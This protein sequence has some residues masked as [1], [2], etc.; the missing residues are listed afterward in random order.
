MK[1]LI[2]GDL[3]FGHKNLKYVNRYFRDELF[4]YIEDNC[5][6]EV[7]CLGDILDKRKTIDFT[8][9]RMLKNFLNFFE[10]NR[11]RFRCIVGNHD[12]YYKNTSNV[13]GIT[14]I[15]E[16]SEYIEFIDRP[17]RIEYDGCSFDF[18]PWINDGNKEEVLEYIK[19][20]TSEY[21]VGHLELSGFDLGGGLKSQSGQ[22][23]IEYL[24]RYKRVFSGHFHIPSETK[25][26][27]YVG[28][29]YE[30]TFADAVRPKRIIVFNTETKEYE[31]I[32]T[33]LKLYEIYSVYNINDLKELEDKDF[34]N[35]YIKILVKSVDINKDEIRYYLDRISKKN[36][37]IISL[38]IKPCEE[39]AGVSS[40]EEDSNISVFDIISK[41]VMVDKN[42]VNQRQVL[43]IL[44][45]IYNIAEVDN[46][47]V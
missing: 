39:V 15:F 27:I 7:I 26:I 41:Y 42:V 14:Q 8:V 30:L 19:S 13:I 16:D 11:V 28:T 21:L 1:V 25:N 10:S 22:M 23:N 38:Y 20:S 17:R 37:D 4:S 3:H 46:G 44:K 24:D 34:N 33:K 32:Y 29:P 2:L 35:K 47:N 9:L 6:G 45:E 18:I 40:I 36:P 43:N 31:N 12:I 5:I